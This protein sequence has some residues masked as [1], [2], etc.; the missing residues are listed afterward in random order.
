MAGKNVIHKRIEYRVVKAANVVAI[1]DT[2]RNSL[3]GREFEENSLQFQFRT[4]AGE[5]ESLEYSLA[6]APGSEAIDNIGRV[7]RVH[8][9]ARIKAGPTC[10]V[11]I[12]HG[13]TDAN[14]ARVT[15]SPAEQAAALARSI[16]Q[17]IDNCAPQGGTFGHWAVSRP[18]LIWVL[19][20]LAFGHAALALGWW[21]LGRTDFA[22]PIG[23]TI[24]LVQALGEINAV[25][26][27]LVYLLAAAVPGLVLA[28]P[29]AGWF[30]HHM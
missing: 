18:W 12:T 6:N 23:Q 14:Y 27:K 13:S 28:I 21:I 24:E 1:A 7:T 4:A 19:T 25:L 8:V 20:S 30:I 2:I 10:H 15:G 26:P 16:S 29:V 9:H 11:S 22:L 5:D 3:N 17:S